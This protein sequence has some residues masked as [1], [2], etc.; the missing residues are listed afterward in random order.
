MKDGEWQRIKE[1]LG[2]SRFRSRFRL[3]PKETDY[4]IKNGPEA[5]RAHAERVIL[6]RLASAY[7]KN[8]GKQTPFRGHPVF[9]AQH[10]TGTCCRNCLWRWHKIPAGIALNSGEIQYV[11]EVIQRWLEENGIGVGPTGA[12][13][14]LE[15]GRI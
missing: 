3:G 11:V 7:P 9:I 12:K 15:P 5:I 14:M 1:R 6:E 13:T 4:F 8:D 2:K 10:A